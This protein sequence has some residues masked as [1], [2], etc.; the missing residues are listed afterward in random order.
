[1]GM[2]APSQ[3]PQNRGSRIGSYAPE[4]EF[5]LRHREC[6]LVVKINLSE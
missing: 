2:G 5:T 3:D 4:G 6:E 1:M